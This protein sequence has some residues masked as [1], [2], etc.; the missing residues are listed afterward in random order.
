VAG[1]TVATALLASV[2]YSALAGSPQAA[3][4]VGLA[5]L[6][7]PYT[8]ITAAESIPAGTFQV[9]G[10]AALKHYHLHDMPEFCRITATVSSVPGSTI[11][12]GVWLPTTTWN[13]RYQQVG[14]HGFGGVFYWSEMAPTAARFRHRD[15]RYWTYR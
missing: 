7:L 13:G 11:G 3:N 1:K 12:I 8:T 6:A 2:A 14:T 4:C 10:T 15:D 5:G 9:P